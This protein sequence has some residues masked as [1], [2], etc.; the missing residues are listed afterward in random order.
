M[1]AGGR[2]ADRK[3][4]ATLI[5]MLAFL[6]FVYVAM[7]FCERSPGLTWVSILLVG[8][9]IG[10]VPP[11]QMIVVTAAKEAPNLASTLLQSA[12]NI[13]ISAGSLIG[14]T[15]LSLGLEYR[16][17][18]LVSMVG[19]IVSLGVARFPLVWAIRNAGRTLHST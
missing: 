13:G 5:G 8:A 18:P 11:L 17:L 6:V 15:A 3:R 7:F 19:A 9:G 14:G 2:L 16:Y 10:T 12:F 1:F 4:V